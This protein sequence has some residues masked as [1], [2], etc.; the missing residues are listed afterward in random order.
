MKTERNSRA[1]TNRKL[2]MGLLIMTF[3]IIA[4]SSCGKNKSQET[5]P[6]E[7][8]PPPPPPPPPAPPTML[9]SDTT[10]TNVEEMPVFPGG[11]EALLKY[12]AENTKYPE[13]AKEQSIQGKILVRF[14]I[15]SKG[16]ITQVSV[17]Q[18]V[19][20]DLDNEAMRVIKTLPEFEPGK[21]G[22]K[23][24]SVWFV[25]PITFTLK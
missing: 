1:L 21:Q 18:G 8:A 14:C 2:L 24:V 10:W 19:S 5:T 22:G 25:I 9:G 12:I 4:F 7:I 6:T 23:P 11:E 3:V 20:P 13:T 15:T 17:L 16:G